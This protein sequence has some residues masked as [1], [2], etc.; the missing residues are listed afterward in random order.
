M[1]RLPTPEEIFVN[2]DRELGEACRALG[3][4]A[5][6]LRSDWA[7]ADVR[8]TAEQAAARRRLQRAV[9]AAKAAIDTARAGGQVPDDGVTGLAYER[10]REE[11]IGWRGLPSLVRVDLGDRVHVT[12]VGGFPLGACSRVPEQ[13]GQG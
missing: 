7:P 1:S 8:L 6:W 2:A 10:E 11:E 3:D 12:E 5:D 4:A 13:R 9:A